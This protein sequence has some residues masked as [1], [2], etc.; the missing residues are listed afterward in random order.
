[1]AITLTGNGIATFM[2]RKNRKIFFVVG[3]G[4]LMILYTCSNLLWLVLDTR[5]PHSDSVIYLQGSY[6]IWESLKAQGVGGLAIL[7]NLL[8]QRPPLQSVLGALLLPFV[9]W[10]PDR[11]LFLNA[12]WQSLAVWLVFVLGRSLGGMPWGIF[13]AVFLMSDPFVHGYLQQFETEIPLMV[14]IAASLAIL[15][16]LWDRA[17]FRD[18]LLLGF[19]IG[20]GLLLKWIYLVIM[21]APLT[22]G[23]YRLWK[24]EAEPSVDTTRNGIENRWW[25]LLLIILIPLVLAG[26]WYLYHLRELVK[27]QDWVS[28][29]N[30][31]TPFVEGWS[32]SV[33][34]Y[35]PSLIALRLKLIHL[36]VLGAGI[37]SILVFYGSR[38]VSGQ[39]EIE[40]TRCRT[41]R[42][43]SLL[44]LSLLFFWLYFSIQYKNLPQKYILPLQ[45]ILAVLAGG[46]TWGIPHRIK[47][48]VWVGISFLFVL[49]FINN[50]WEY[51]AWIS[52][53]PKTA[54]PGP[55][56]E[57][58][59]GLWIYDPRTPQKAFFSHAELVR[60]IASSTPSPDRETRIMVVPRLRDFSFFTLSVWLQSKFLRMESIGFSSP[61]NFSDLIVHDYLVTSRGQVLDGKNRKDRMQSFEYDATLKL[62]RILESEP[63]CFASTHRLIGQY[64]YR[65][66][67]P[68]YLYRRISPVTSREISDW[69]GYFIDDV[70]RYPLWDESAFLWKRLGDMTHVERLRLMQSAWS[71]ND[72]HA[73]Q[74]LI[75]SDKEG[76]VGWEPY[77][78][79][80]LGTLFLRENRTDRGVVLLQE[81]AN[82]SSSCAFSAAKTL[83]N[84][85]QK[86]DRDLESMPWFEHAG[87]LNLYDSQIFAGLA[88]AKERS[89]HLDQVDPIRK[90]QDLTEQ[91]TF[92][93]DQPELMLDASLILRKLGYEDWARKYER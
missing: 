28:Q 79:Y 90:L 91:L 60:D 53:Y 43:I 18:F 9:N 57:R 92:R 45:P 25:G 14:C 70:I 3:M 37:F 4:L 1:M 42:A 86:I 54:I 84:Y 67:V 20:M 38:S 80:V 16:R 35:Y 7:G 29:S 88:L 77:E 66:S 44:F 59:T 15:I 5:P 33:L 51:P 34:W 47:H 83:A 71:K 63:D 69:I 65:N 76:L 89:G 68:V 39:G 85:F 62:A 26:P 49:I 82:S 27:Y 19:L 58:Q 17:A 56:L 55:W 11:V 61:Q 50:Q 32:F 8:P 52:A 40:P 36:I 81:I 6:R 41:R 30:F 24:R 93:S 46:V 87:K 72:P 10:V 12:I 23:C 31:F 64:L 21:G 2:E 13:S 75:Q 78:R 48:A 22:Y 74:R 73:V